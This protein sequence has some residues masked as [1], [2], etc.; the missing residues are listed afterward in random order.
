V[1]EEDEQQSKM[2]ISAR[3]KVDGLSK[4]MPGVK[5]PFDFDRRYRGLKPAATP[6]TRE[7][8]FFS[9]TAG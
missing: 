9:A 1:V 4:R 8:D 3:L 7:A 5:T 6:K 2:Q